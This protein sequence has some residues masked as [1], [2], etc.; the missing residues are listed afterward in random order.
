M[1]RVFYGVQV[2]CGRLTSHR[3][4]AGRALALT[5]VTTKN[6]QVVLA[7]LSTFQKRTHKRYQ[8]DDRCPR[9]AL[10]NQ[11]A[12]AFCSSSLLAVDRR[13]SCCMLSRA[14]IHAIVRIMRCRPVGGW[15]EGGERRCGV[16]ACHGRY[17]LVPDMLG[18]CRE[19]RLRTLRWSVAYHSLAA[20][21]AQLGRCAPCNVFSTV[22]TQR[23]A[24]RSRGAA[25]GHPR[26]T[27]MQAK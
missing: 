5:C 14:A 18:V 3:S 25:F 17:L 9:R 7:Q 19:C 22:G 27:S 16:H 20:A 12:V 23:V 13:Y 21:H 2:A 15:P 1:Y 8:P 24:R 6:R 4:R 10:P 26:G 11:A